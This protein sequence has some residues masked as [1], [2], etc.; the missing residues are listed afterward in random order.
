MK[1]LMFSSDYFVAPIRS[2]HIVGVM[3]SP[4]GETRSIQ[5]QRLSIIFSKLSRRSSLHSS[6]SGTYL[7]GSAIWFLKLV[8]ESTSGYPIYQLDSCVPGFEKLNV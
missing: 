3:K 5:L 6:A 1:Y 8:S 2:P 4:R 7:T